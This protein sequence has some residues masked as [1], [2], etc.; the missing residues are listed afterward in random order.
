[1]GNSNMIE[2]VPV[3]LGGREFILPPLSLGFIRRN[4]AMLQGMDK[5]SGEDSLSASI[6]VLHAALSR[7]YP[8]LAKEELEDL[9]DMRNIA[10]VMDALKNVSGFAAGE[11]TPGTA[12]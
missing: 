10:A 5:L 7:N 8:E 3:M 6:T 4:W 11:V 9:L 1:M 2:G 12:G